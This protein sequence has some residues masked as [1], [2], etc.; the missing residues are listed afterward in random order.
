MDINKL[1]DPLGLPQTYHARHAR[2][3]RRGP[4]FPLSLRE[5]VRVRVPVTIVTHT[6]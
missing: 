4:F 1:A 2:P 3:C 5:R 6:L